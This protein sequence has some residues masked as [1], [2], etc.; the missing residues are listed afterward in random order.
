LLTSDTIDLVNFLIDNISKF[1]SV[2]QLK[3]NQV[4]IDVPK[5]DPVNNE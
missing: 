2:I 5:V 4:K 3:D 1:K